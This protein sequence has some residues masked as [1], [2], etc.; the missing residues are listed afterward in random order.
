MEIAIAA[1]KSSQEMAMFRS[2]QTGK[3]VVSKNILRGSLKTFFHSRPP[4]SNCSQTFIDSGK[5]IDKNVSTQDDPQEAPKQSRI[6]MDLV[7]GRKKR[8]KKKKRTKDKCTQTKE[9]KATQTLAIVL[10]TNFCCVFN[11]LTFKF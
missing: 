7:R 8:K 5:M 2:Q 11:N 1:D 6:Y 10:S 3:C 9:R 4:C